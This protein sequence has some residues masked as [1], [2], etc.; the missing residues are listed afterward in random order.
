MKENRL[1]PSIPSMLAG[2]DLPIERALKHLERTSRCWPMVLSDTIIF[3]MASVSMHSDIIR[4]TLPT[5][6]HWAAR[7]LCCRAVSN[8]M[9]DMSLSFVTGL[10]KV[11]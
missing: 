2:P 11:Y 7:G 9:Q 5:P 10:I 6:T 8:L 4:K 3:N 1:A